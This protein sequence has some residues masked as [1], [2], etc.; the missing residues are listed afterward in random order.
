MELDSRWVKEAVQLGRTGVVPGSADPGWAPVGPSLHGS[1]GGV[2]CFRCRM[3]PHALL[4][5]MA[6]FRDKYRIN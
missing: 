3:G 4:A 1:A 6:L 5:Y 2:R